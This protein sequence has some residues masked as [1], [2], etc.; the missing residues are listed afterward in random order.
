MPAEA[1][2]KWRGRKVNGDRDARLTAQRVSAIIGPSFG[3]DL[4]ISHLVETPNQKRAMP[5]TVRRECDFP[6]DIENR[7]MNATP[8]HDTDHDLKITKRTR[9]AAG[10]GTW[11]CG[12]IDDEFRF[13]ALVFPE[14]AENPEYEI[15]ESRISKL[16]VARMKNKE[17]V[18]NWDRGLD[19]DSAKTRGVVGFLCEGLADL[20][21]GG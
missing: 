13:D 2:D 6:S 14:H 10:T 20:V 3:A 4:N 7:V 18:Y 8:D 16:W 21:Y 11:I 5:A 19:V 17:T 12:T 15:G 9:Q 1:P